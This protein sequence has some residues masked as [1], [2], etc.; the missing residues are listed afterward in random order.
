MKTPRPVN[1]CLGRARPQQG[2]VLV[3][4]LVVLTLLFAAASGLYLNR[5]MWSFASVK[6]LDRV[7]MDVSSRADA[8]NWILQFRNTWQTAGEWG[9]PQNGVL[10]LTSSPVALSGGSVITVPGGGNFTAVSPYP[11]YPDILGS[12]ELP[13]I[14]S[15]AQ[16]SS[17]AP[18][19]SGEPFWGTRSAVG[20]LGVIFRRE[21]NDSTYTERK[22]RFIRP[23]STGS[24]SRLRAWFSL[25]GALPLTMVFRV[26]PVSVFT[27]F[28][29]QGGEAGASDMVELGSWLV[30]DTFPYSVGDYSVSE[31]GVGRVYVEGKAKAVSEISTGFPMVATGGFV[32]SSSGITLN[33]PIVFGGSSHRA[34]WADDPDF[35]DRRHSDFRGMLVTSSD[36]PARLLRRDLAFAD[37]RWHCPD[38]SRLTTRMQN[39]GVG[40]TITATIANYANLDKGLSCSSDP[41]QLSSGDQAAFKNPLYWAWDIPNKELVFTPPAGF[42]GGFSPSPGSL[43]VKFVGADKNDYTFRIALPDP[44][45]DFTLLVP[46]NPVVLQDGFNRAGTRAAMVVS[47]RIYVDGSSPEIR[48]V[49][50]TQGTFPNE[51]IL[52]K[53]AGAAPNVLIQG[54]L[55]LWRR[56]ASVPAGSYVAPISLN[57]VD[58][59]L[60]GVWIPPLTPAVTDV[61]ASSDGF[62]VYDIKAVEP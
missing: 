26:L 2:F 34:V 45:R 3:L 52:Y 6:Q 12:L 62:R 16:A 22:D 42:I 48:G 55:V 44:G 30:S 1:P 27:L 57:P 23:D 8:Q 35:L 40:V 20:G 53:G 19:I 15:T 14:F 29:G 37:G 11:K 4:A 18:Y 60:S 51:A 13:Y 21:M 31:V 58:N 54:A 59:Y 17:P 46:E 61:R 24:G 39:S 36:S 5:Q 10:N 43:C 33:F 28:V 9:S 50:I 47:P 41:S 7:A 32:E 49:V 38:F 25:D 56:L